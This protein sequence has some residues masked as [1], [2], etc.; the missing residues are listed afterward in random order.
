MNKQTS[1]MFV[2]A[3]ALIGGTALG[4][5]QAKTHQKLGAPGVKTEPIPGSVRLEIPLPEKVLDYSSVI[6]PMDTNILEGLPHDT[7]FMQRLYQGATP[8][9]SIQMNV[10]LMGTD[11]TS[12]HRPQFCLAG[13]GWNI[14]DAESSFDSVRIEKPHPYDLPVMKLTTSREVTVEGGRAVK[15]RGIFVYWLVADH[16]LAARHEIAMW[17]IGTHLLRTGELERWAYVFC[18]ARCLPG[19]EAVTYDRVKKFIGA[20]VPEFQL[21]TGPSAAGPG[22]V[23]SAAP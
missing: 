8:E 22:P 23:A 12:M 5:H 17:K 19:D 6:V 10:V 4:L 3:L 21:A 20:A 7:S 13:S 16:D 2:L 11:R 1:T 15:V 9:Q 14:D 18:F